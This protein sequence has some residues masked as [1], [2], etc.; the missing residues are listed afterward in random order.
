MYSQH[1]L[2][3]YS[4]KC[5]YKDW[6]YKDIINIIIIF[7]LKKERV[8]D[9]YALESVNSFFEPVHHWTVWMNRFKTNQ[10]F[11]HHIWSD[12]LYLS[13]LN[14]GLSS[15]GCKATWTVLCDKISDVAQQNMSCNK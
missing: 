15:F 6:R 7:K 2:K 4:A 1:C 12:D 14:Y 3:K 8:S 13:V 10:T 5:S 9:V 11:Q